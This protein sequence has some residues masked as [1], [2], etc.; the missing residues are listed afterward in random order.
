MFSVIADRGY[1]PWYRLLWSHDMT[2][3]T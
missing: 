2:L 1:Q 3:N